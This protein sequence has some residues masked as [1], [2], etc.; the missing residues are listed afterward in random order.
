MFVL[1]QTGDFGSG[2]TPGS[3][4]GGV[5]EGEGGGEG[6]GEGGTGGDGSGTGGGDG[7]GTRTPAR[8]NTKARVANSIREDMFLTP[9]I[10]YVASAVSTAAWSVVVFFTWASE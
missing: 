9:A 6:V 10:S 8:Y 3:R 2:R 5:G 1:D 7:T 4:G